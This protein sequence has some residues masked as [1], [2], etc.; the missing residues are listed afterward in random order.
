MADI[1][2]NIPADVPQGIPINDKPISLADARP[3]IPVVPTAPVIGDAQL[4]AAQDRLQRYKEGK[5]IYDT[6]IIENEDWWKFLH[7]QN[8][9]RH[10]AKMENKRQEYN[11]KPVSGW[12]FNSI[13]MKHADAMDN[14]PEPSV[15]PRARDDE[16]AAKKLSS[17]IPV[18]LENSR[19]EAAYSSAWWDKLKNGVGIYGVFYNTRLMNGVGDIDIRPID[20][21][22]FYWEPGV[23]NIQDSKDIFLLTLRDNDQL[24]SAHPQLKGKLR[25]G[26]VTHKQYHFDDHVDT[27]HK[28]VVVDWYYKVNRNGRDVLHYVQWVDDVILYA[29]EDDP[30]YAEEG[31][32][33]HGKYPFVFDVLFEEKGSPAGFGY[34]DVMRNPQEFIDRLDG[35]ILDNAIWASKPRY[36]QKDN[37]GVNEE[38]FLDTTK[39]I[40]HTTGSPN[41]DNLRPI[42]TRE[43]SGNVLSVLQAKI[44]ELKETSGNRDFSQGSTVSGV[45]AASAIA[46]LQEAGSKGSR[47]MLKGSYRAFTEICNFVVELI[48]QFYDLPRTFRI[49]G[50]TGSPDY[51]DFDN[52]GMQAVETTEYGMD[53]STKEP[54]FDIKIKAQR[55][56]PYSRLAQNELAMQFYSAGF[57]NPQLADQALATIDMMDFEGK[58]KVRE[59]IRNNGTMYEQIQ[60]MQQTMMQ[61]AD[62]IAGMNGDTRL[63]TA[64]QQQMGIAGMSGA[65][66]TQST[67]SASAPRPVAQQQMGGGST[68]EKAAERAKEATTVR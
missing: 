31:F 55:S 45:T 8:F 54:I 64:I 39:Q 20:V 13:M 5:I 26:T 30:K 22:N 63:L 40:V 62:L 28:S 58:E 61:M 52:A 37:A 48:R 60:Q 41:E 4:K 21:L 1:P 24:E 27:S 7:W 38:E 46:A 67:Q 29:S 47:D 15:L 10:P 66:S 23:Q 9:H 11:A 56:S 14:F 33:R 17:I 12:L 34:I 57:F 49:I 59:T 35:S 32:Y 68:Y 18:V 43:L 3:I 25:D 44:D 53:F 6:R 19:F 16:D 65:Q 42:E 50:E 36:F 2:I 51:I